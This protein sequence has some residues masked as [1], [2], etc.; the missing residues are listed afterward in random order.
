MSFKIINTTITKFK[1]NKA[2]GCDSFKIGIMKELWKCKPIVLSNLFNN[3]F[4]QEMFL[5]LWKKSSLKIIPKEEKRD[6]TIKFL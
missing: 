3:C 4:D 2:P 1:N 5:K 6:R